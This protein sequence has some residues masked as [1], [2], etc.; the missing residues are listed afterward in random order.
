MLYSEEALREEPDKI[1]GISPEHYADIKEDE[2]PVGTDFRNS[3]EFA[4]I[5]F[6]ELDDDEKFECKRFFIVPIPLKR[7]I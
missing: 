2:V 3:E 6:W 1:S 5:A 7:E 4:V